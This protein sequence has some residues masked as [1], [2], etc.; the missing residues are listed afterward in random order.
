MTDTLGVE[1]SAVPT[2]APAELTTV[3]VAVAPVASAG[4]F[5]SAPVSTP[6]GLPSP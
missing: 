1:P 2:A 5:A 6:A 3:A 4:P